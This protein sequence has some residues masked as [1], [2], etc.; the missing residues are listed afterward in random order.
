L[1][2]GRALLE[3]G[4]AAGAEIELARAQELGRPASEVAPLL[5][6]ALL[7]Q[8]E[9]DKL[10]SRLGAVELD[11]AQAMVDLQLTLATA[12]AARGSPDKA[13]E[14][15]GK[16]LARSP[17]SLPALIMLA[18]LKATAGDSA[19]ALAALDELLA[20]HADAADAWQLKGDV[21]AQGK[22]DL[23]GAI[24]AYE[25]ALALEPARA[26]L[27][28]GL[29]TLYFAQGDL[30]AAGRQF[31]AMK[32]AAPD[33]P[34]SR[35]YE[36]QLVYARGDYKLAQQK[37]QDLLRLAPDNASLLHLAGATELQLGA[38]PQAEFLL[39]KAVQAQPGFVA[40]RVL[41]AKTY[42]RGNQPA[43]ALAVLGPALDAK[44]VDSETLVTAGQAALLG[45]DAK[46]ANG[47]FA[48]AAAAGPRDV[49]ARTA[50]AMSQLSK[51]MA[52]AAFSELQ[53]I[54]AA[55]A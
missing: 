37:L 34:L 19:G 24:A 20:G 41:L 39:A 8:G 48:R 46:A 35:F 14:A 42:L 5:A 38:L 22:A 3:S 29:L 15:I 23:P 36:A 55:H 27:H 53:S 11:N 28:A 52:D 33:N 43:K 4:D 26:E 13:R 54:A 1:L 30:K 9:Y 10:T 25:K 18:R 50:A 40:A 7:A 16:A 49:R 32:A 12:Y 2:L 51:G 6:K 45:S 44:G 17:Q 21:L 47:Y 31:D